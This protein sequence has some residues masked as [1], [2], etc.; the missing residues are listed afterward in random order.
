M[1][2]WFIAFISIVFLAALPASLHAQIT[3]G[4]RVEFKPRAE[5]SGVAAGSASFASLG[6]TA[7]DAM[8]GFKLGTSSKKRFGVEGT[9]EQSISYRDLR[10]AGGDFVVNFPRSTSNSKTVPFLHV[11]AGSY[12]DDNR[13]RGALSFGAGVKHYFNDHVG[14][15]FGVQDRLIFQNSTMHRLDVYGGIIFRF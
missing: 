15:R 6:G 8:W 2:N 4:P 10:Y 9:F 12:F 13:G 7:Y 5:L 3:A 1:K 14:F 11:G